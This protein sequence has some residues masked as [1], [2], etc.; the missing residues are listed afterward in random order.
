MKRAGAGILL[1]ALLAGQVAVAADDARIEA[2]RTEI[3]ELSDDRIESLFT[4]LFRSNGCALSM[5]EEEATDRRIM[6]HFGAALGLSVDEAEVVH[7]QLQDRIQKV[8]IS[9]VEGGV[10]EPDMQAGVVRLK[11][12]TPDIAGHTV[13]G[14]GVVTDAQL[15]ALVRT[16]FEGAGCAMD[17]SDQMAAQS[18]ILVSV[19]EGLGVAD[20]AAA[21]APVDVALAGVFESLVQSGELTVDEA[22]MTVSLADCN[23]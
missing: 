17:F 4:D 2:L 8:S 1:A 12:C 3:S 6:S 14:A 9:M 23:G 21:R 10:I 18:A 20:E 22:D 15:A 5:V 19:L 13:P 11:D 16:H 7:D